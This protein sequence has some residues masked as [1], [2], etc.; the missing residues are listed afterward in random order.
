MEIVGGYREMRIWHWARAIL[1][2]N[3]DLGKI[4]NDTHDETLE[5]VCFG[6]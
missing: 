6:F 1:V 2:F 4:M 5:K 3:V